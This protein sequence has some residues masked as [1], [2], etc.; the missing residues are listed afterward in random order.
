M[1]ANILHK[2]LFDSEID[3]NSYF[4]HLK[5]NILSLNIRISTNYFCIFQKSIYI[6]FEWI[7][8]IILF[9]VRDKRM[10]E[11]NLTNSV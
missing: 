2:L 4:Q 8:L 3:I 1:Y 11:N 5:A 10:Q 6:Y 7:V 9:S